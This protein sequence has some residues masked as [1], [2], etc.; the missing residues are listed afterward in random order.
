VNNNNFTFGTTFATG[1]WNN[2]G[3]TDVSDRI[4]WNNNNFTFASATPSA[5]IPAPQLAE[6]PP[7]A[8][9]VSDGDAA[10][11]AAAYA[12]QGPAAS[13]GDPADPA[14]D[15][16]TAGTDALMAVETTT[17]EAPMVE[18]SSP[19][20][21]PTDPA[22][23]PDADA[24]ASAELEPD[25]QTDLPDVLGVREQLEVAVIRARRCIM[26]RVPA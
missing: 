22:A 9:A 26:E 20:A 11:L 25:I 15:S 5:Q 4:V 1:D 21:S 10:A 16:D 17:N 19:E 13:Q 24:P 14:A 7:A 8:E 3:R 18:A 12:V 23:W 6:A 2:D